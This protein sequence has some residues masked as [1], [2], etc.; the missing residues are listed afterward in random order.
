MDSEETQIALRRA[1]ARIEQSFDIEYFTYWPQSPHRAVAKDFSPTGI[2][3]VAIDNFHIGQVVKIESP[4]LRAVAQ[5][6]NHEAVS[7]TPTPIKVG[8]KFMTA[9]FN[10][11]PGTFVAVTV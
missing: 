1:A 7:A 4:L 5:V 8:L 2:A 10:L 9:S 11:P 6:K 3:I